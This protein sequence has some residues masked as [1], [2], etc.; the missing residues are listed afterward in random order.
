M[1]V[2]KAL[3]SLKQWV[4][5]RDE[6]GRKVPYQI[7]GKPAKSNEPGTWNTLE[8]VISCSTKKTGIGFV[9][10]D[11][12]GLCGIDLDQAITNGEIAS[13]AIEILERCKSYAEISPSGNGIKIFGVGSLPDGRGKNI[14]LGESENGNKAPGIEVYDRGRYFTFT[15][16]QYD[17]LYPE[18]ADIGEAIEYIWSKY[19]DAKPVAITP[20]TMPA[21]P[22]IPA[23]IEDRA[24]KY[25]QHVPPA[26]SGQGGHNQTFRAACVLV[27][28]FGLSPD[29]AYPILDGW[30]QSCQPPWSE[31]DLRHKLSDADK[32][33][34]E[35]GQL[36]DRK[37]YDPSDIHVDLSAIVRQSNKS[38]H[39]SNSGNSGDPGPFPESCLRP[40][41]LLNEIID[42]SLAGSYYEQPE[43]SLAAA[44]SIMSAI[45]GRKIRDKQ[46]T[47]TNLY[48]VA[49]GPSGCGKDY[50][51]Q[52]I[53]LIL[54]SAGLSSVHGPERIASHAGLISTMCANLCVL[55][56]ID[57]VGKLL[58]TTKDSSK[59]PH[60]FSIITVLLQLYSSANQIWKADAYA[61]N[62][63]NREINQPHCVIFGTTTPET[64][65]SSLS[66]KN[67][68]DGFFGRIMTFFSRGYVDRNRKLSLDEPPPE[69]VEKIKAW[70]D[71]VPKANRIAGNLAD[72]RAKP[73]VDVAETT[74]A[75]AERYFS[76][77][78][79]IIRRRNSDS[80]TN[81]AIWSR[82]GEKTA[83]LALIAACSDCEPGGV[84]IE[85]RHVDWA[86][87]VA[88]WLTRKMLWAITERVGENA[89]E[90]IYLR[91]LAS[92][93][94]DGITRTALLRR[95]RWIRSR[96]LAEVLSRM[97]ESGEIE[98]VEARSH[99]RTAHIYRRSLVADEQG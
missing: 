16:Q 47:R 36:V 94:Y 46:G 30:N 65:W 32:H 9:F 73:I 61:D 22:A 2:P 60:L 5:W 29:R 28:G 82:S 68:A 13:W 45:T 41:G 15:G 76:H 1:H 93:R 51:R 35:R 38:T 77:I 31:K 40:G 88:N 44:I 4:I 78:D 56:P 3:K 62:S 63:K 69:L 19:I 43:L 11:S 96:D 71:Y 7:N 66:T 58:E 52:A 27:I 83:K 84:V 37:H 87:Q 49:V 90:E 34:G 80:P 33:S 25:L 67:V 75:A 50:P 81:A 20:I 74:S 23:S 24:A 95:C 12:D 99:G 57:E 86:I 26:V 85:L 48:I 55:F 8:N 14:K 98:Y 6:I 97:I 72:L 79:E 89:I 17:E 54:H 18:I 42:Y 59:Q 10:S 21:I 91:V 64:F 70:G 92:I 53:K 39:R